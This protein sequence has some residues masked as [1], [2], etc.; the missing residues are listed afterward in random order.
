MQN[1]INMQNECMHLR[2][3]KIWD[4]TR[5]FSDEMRQSKRCRVRIMHASLAGIYD[6]GQKGM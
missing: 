5:A 2:L 3:Y 1:A 6:I 4:A